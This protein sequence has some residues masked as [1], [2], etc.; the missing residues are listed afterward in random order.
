MSLKAALA[1]AAAAAFAAADDIPDAVLLRRTIPGIYNPATGKTGPATV[2]D[3]PAQAVMGSYKQ[4][5]INGTSI[6]TT[7]R[8][9]TLRQAEVAAAGTVITSDKLVLAGVAKT[10]VNVQQ[11]AAGVLWVLQVRG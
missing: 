10:I 5:E 9:A 3:Y 2:T 6:L 4:N 1:S 8:R 7:D 11:D